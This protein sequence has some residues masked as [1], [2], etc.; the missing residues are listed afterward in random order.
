MSVVGTFERFW[1]I[2]SEASFNAA[3]PGGGAAWNIGGNG[4]GANGW[5]DLP[6][7]RESDG[8]QPKSTIIYPSTAAGTRAMNSALPIAGAYP[9]ELGSLEFAVYP[10]LID[11]IFR[12]V[13]GSVARTPTAGNAA[14]SS[15]AF[16]S[17]AALDTQSNGTEQLKFVIASSSAASAAAINIIQSAATQ[18]TITIGTSA[19]SVDG[20]YY[21]KGAYDGTTN[22]ITFSVDGTVTDGMVVVSGIDKN[23]NVFTAGDT[24]P[25]LVIEQAGRPEADLGSSYSEYFPGIVIPTLQLAYDRSAADS[26]LTATA[27]IL[28]LNPTRATAGSYANDAATYYR[29]FAGWTGAITT[30]GGSWAEVVAANI[31]IQPNNE[32]YATSSGTQQPTGEV[33]GYFEVFGTLTILPEDETQWDAYRAQTIQDVELTFT[34]PH[35]IVDTTGY[36]LKLEFTQLSI[37]DYSRNAQGMA[38]GAEIAFR[39]IYDSSDGPCKAT[40]V[41]RMPV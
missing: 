30:D 23:T 13:F 10:E 32:L 19:G 36:S 4:G 31:T 2:R 35:Y 5:M 20:D 41:S 37:E 29:P 9:A 33:E 18:E 40:V 3:T 27:T 15:I 17:L 11:R 1:R 34:T 28:G 14:K 25:S 22:A 21:S 24:N 16:A 6:V 38:Q 7:T 26:L 39:T 8:L 12:Q